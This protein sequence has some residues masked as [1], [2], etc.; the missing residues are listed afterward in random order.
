MTDSS[1][2]S[3]GP[4]HPMDN[5]ALGSAGSTTFVLT[6]AIE[7]IGSTSNAQNAQSTG[8]LTIPS[9]NT[10]EF[11]AT[12]P[13]TPVLEPQTDGEE[14][15][16]LALDSAGSTTFLLT[17]ADEPAGPSSNVHNTQSTDNLTVPSMDTS[18]L[19][20]TLSP[21]PVLKP[22]TGGEEVP[23]LSLDNEQKASSSADAKQDNSTVPSRR[24]LPVSNLVLQSPFAAN[25]HLKFSSDTPMWGGTSRV[26]SS[27]APSLWAPASDTSSDDVSSGESNSDDSDE[28]FSKVLLI[29][30]L[31]TQGP[32]LANENLGFSLD[33]SIPQLTCPPGHVEPLRTTPQPTSAPVLTNKRL[34]AL[35]DA[36]ASQPTCV[37]GHVAPPVSAAKVSVT[38]SAPC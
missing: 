9:T 20:A 28:S 2:S 32:S 27:S 37:P 6:P 19:V 7:S 12:M 29:S 17:P 24:I 18:E 36:S 30:D 26:S 31:S 11:V 22:Q 25:E 3:S 13:P 34:K 21:T 5:V 33:S 10:A 38:T 14:V 15:L 1:A 23:P 16:A 4:S 35:A 8:N